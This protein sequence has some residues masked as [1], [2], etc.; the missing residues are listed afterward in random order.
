[1]S[2][3]EIINN[4]KGYDPM[5]IDANGDYW[6]L[7]YSGDWTVETEFGWFTSAE[8][9]NKQEVKSYRLDESDKF[10]YI[11]ITKSL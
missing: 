3:N 8:E 6:T 2:I 11:Y 4:N 5:V 1:M 7:T 10:I 9:M